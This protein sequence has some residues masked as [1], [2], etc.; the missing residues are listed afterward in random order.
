ME[1]KQKRYQL[2]QKGKKYILS[3]QTFQDKLRFVCI[4]VSSDK[5]IIYIGQF[6]ILE[7]TKISSVF[8]F[9][10]EISEA[11][12]LFDEMIVKQK[13]NIELKENYL[14]LNI[15]I[16][17]QNKPDEKFTIKLI[18]FNRANSGVNTQNDTKS[19]NVVINQNDSTSDYNKIDENLVYS[20]NTENK[21]KQKNIRYT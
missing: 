9:V 4:E 5:Q 19:T 15:L 16:K 21:Q 18:L 10:T 3:I 7:L 12:D 14:N 13:I 11:L 8:S 1:S 2:E 17:N 20:P 6:N